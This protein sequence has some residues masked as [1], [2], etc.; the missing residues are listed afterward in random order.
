MS[1]SIVL[2]EGL[3]SF[4]LPGFTQNFRCFLHKTSFR[5]L[6]PASS[7]DKPLLRN[8][9][10][11]HQSRSLPSHKWYGHD[12]WKDLH[13]SRLPKSEFSKQ[14]K[15]GNHSRLGNIILWNSSGCPHSELKY[16]TLSTPC[17]DMH[18]A[19][20]TFKTL[21]VLSLARRPHSFA[22]RLDTYGNLLSMQERIKS[23]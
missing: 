23:Y 21:F 20:L 9:R 16:N 7:F 11:K 5:S 14:L 8:T 1:A 22:R 15:L 4:V 6:I 3:P 10:F 19:S 18:T 12:T 2:M 17:W 13:Q